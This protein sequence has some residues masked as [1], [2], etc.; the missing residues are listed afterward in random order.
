VHWGGILFAV[1]VIGLAIPFA[2]SHFRTSDSPLRTDGAKTLLAVVVIAALSLG[3]VNV[4][5]AMG[6]F[7]NQAAYWTLNIALSAFFWLMLLRLCWRERR[8]RPR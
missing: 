3:F 4:V 6:G 8:Q 5:R 7:E 1:L 2:L